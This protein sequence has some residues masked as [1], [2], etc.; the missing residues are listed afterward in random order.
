M[1]VPLLLKLF[2]F[3]V[4][5]SEFNSSLFS[6]ISSLIPFTCFSLIPFYLHP[7]VYS[8]PLF[9]SLNHFILLKIIINDDYI[10]DTQGLIKLL[11]RRLLLQWPVA[12]SKDK[13]RE[14]S[15]GDDCHHHRQN[16]YKLTI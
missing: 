5:R 9:N 13:A 10:M 11:A 6:S 3:G 8:G 15:E 16:K 2:F 14:V 4:E 1:F 12:S 7:H